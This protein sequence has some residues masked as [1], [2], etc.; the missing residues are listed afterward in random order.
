[1]KEVKSYEAR[2]GKIFKTKEKCLEYKEYYND[3]IN[4]V[5]DI[6]RHCNFTKDTSEGS[7][8][9]CPFCRDEGECFLD[10]NCVDSW[11][12]LFN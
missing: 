6:S 9:D 2:N 3:L 5:I 10:C 11:Q 8:G 7:C 1:M 4:A 12:D